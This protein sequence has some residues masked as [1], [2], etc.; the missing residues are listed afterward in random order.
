MTKLFKEYSHSVNTAVI[1]HSSNDKS[2]KE[3]QVNNLE[4]TKLLQAS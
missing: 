1:K 4:S 2:L 3:L